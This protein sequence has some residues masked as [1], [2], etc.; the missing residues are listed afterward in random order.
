[1][2]KYCFVSIKSY[3]INF[4]RHCIEYYTVDLVVQLINIVQDIICI[5]IG[6]FNPFYISENTL[7]NINFY[8][9]DIEDADGKVHWK[10]FNHDVEYEVEKA[11][12]RLENLLNDKNLGKLWLNTD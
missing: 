7:L 12:F 10:I 2:F 9:E 4:S 8:Y 6:K 3:N 1:M 5:Y 11:V